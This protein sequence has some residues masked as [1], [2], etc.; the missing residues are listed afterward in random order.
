[1]ILIIDFKAVDQTFVT[2]LTLY[3][4]FQFFKVKKHTKLPHLAVNYKGL[5]L[6]H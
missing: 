6:H 2:C 4:N 5:S 3:D 1:M